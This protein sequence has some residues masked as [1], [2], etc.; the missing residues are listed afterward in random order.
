MKNTKLRLFLVMGIVI[1]L[2]ACSL[3][4]G[5]G[6]SSLGCVGNCPEISVDTDSFDKDPTNLITATKTKYEPIASSSVVVVPMTSV[7]V[8]IGDGYFCPTKEVKGKRE[9]VWKRPG[10]HP[11]SGTVG[12]A[13]GLFK[14]VPKEVRTAW[15]KNVAV[16]TFTKRT[17][18]E[19]ERSCGMFYTVDGIKGSYHK[20]WRN[21]KNGAWVNEENAKNGANVTS[22]EHGGYIW[23]L[24][25]PDICA[26]VS[27]VA[28][29]VATMS[30]APVVKSATLSKKTLKGGPNFLT[31]VLFWEWDSI[32]VD[33]QNKIKEVNSTESNE[34]YAVANGSVSRDLNN[35][36]ITSWKN[37]K[38]TTVTVP[39]TALVKYP[40]SNDW[41]QITAGPKDHPDEN[42]LVYW[43]K[44]IS[45]AGATV[46][47]S[48]FFVKMSSQRGCKVIYPRKSND[49]RLLSTRVNPKGTHGEL[50][51]IA[52]RGDKAIALNVVMDCP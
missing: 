41:E 12:L 28:R 39:I 21:V 27:Y 43:E 36:L 3:Q 4:L 6:N 22:V 15:Q 9:N 14:N 19:G 33:L 17:L 24:V 47:N 30:V 37:G 45:R 8:S 40:G 11:Y 13:I 16:N 48:Q 26:N 52:L 49:G 5:D 46:P 20:I 50:A 44:E 34:S 51:S 7:M 1:V 35:D 42:G 32:P 31:Q 10:A 38:A 2:S 18:K 29:K 25:I 23:D